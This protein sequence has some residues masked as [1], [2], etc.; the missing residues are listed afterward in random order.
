MSVN[1]SYINWSESQ[2]KIASRIDT[3]IKTYEAIFNKS[4]LSRNKQFWSICGQNVSDDKTPREHGEYLHLLSEGL[5]KP[6]QYFGVEKN[7]KW[8]Q[9]NT[10]IEGPNWLC[11]DFYETMLKQ[12]KTTFNPAIVN[13]DHVKMPKVGISYLA[14]VISLLHDRK[15]QDVMVVCNL[16]LECY[17]HKHSFIDMPSNLINHRLFYPIRDSWNMHSEI[18]VYDGANENKKTTKMGTMIIWKY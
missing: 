16:I 18:Y 4:S 2:R 1:T 12:D 9:L 5:F 7:K 13:V 11:G 15:I 14:K 17:C 6:E 8:H 3:I 10:T